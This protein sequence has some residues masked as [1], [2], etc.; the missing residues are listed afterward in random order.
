MPDAIKDTDIHTVAQ[1]LNAIAQNGLT[2]A[3]DVFDKERYETLRQIAEDLLR[4]RFNIDAETL[5]PV[6]ESGYAT[7]KTD[8]RAFIIRDG[9]LLM[10]KE[11]EDGKWSL[12]GGW[13]DVGDTPSAAVCREVV[14]ETGLEV[15]VI[16]LLGVW[17]RNLHGHPPLPWHVYK[18]IFL[19]EETG[20]SL[21][22]SHESTDI[23]FFDINDLPELSLTRIVP[24]ELIVSMEIATSDRQPWYD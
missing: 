2:Y 16:K 18:L 14:E 23:G 11:A 24:E 3:K 21:A 19:C 9:R 5:T 12:P 7:P 8:V 20:G 15:K 17:D 22:T 6:S 10:V 4:A 1:K 13:A